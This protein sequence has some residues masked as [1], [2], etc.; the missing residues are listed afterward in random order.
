VTLY[1]LILLTWQREYLASWPIRQHY[2]T[3]LGLLRA[4][5][6]VLAISQKTADDAVS[7]LG[8]DRR[9]VFVV[10]AGVSELFAPALRPREVIVTNLRAKLPTLRPGFFLYAGATDPR[11]NLKS[12]IE[13]YA[14][15]PEK[16]RRERQ[17]VIVSRLPGV[18]GPALQQLTE[19]LGIA[20]QTLWTDYVPDEALACLYQACGAFVFPSLY[21]GF[22]LP[23]VEAQRCGAPVLAGDNS[24]LR[25]VVP[26]AAARFDAASPQAIAAAL[27]KVASDAPFREELA[28]RGRQWAARYSWDRVVDASLA[29][30]E[31]VWNQPFSKAELSS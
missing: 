5:D 2:L 19:R 22:G 29:A 9:R 13:A 7:L 12:L 3:R 6:A 31:S 17:L 20:P 26:D 30:Y 10:H 4:A 25:E 16:T 27:E 11:K 14:L 1:D 18:D 24:S 23:V 21:E 15:L 8:L 28:E